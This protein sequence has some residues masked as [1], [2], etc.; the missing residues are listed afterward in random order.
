MIDEIEH[1]VVDD[2]DDGEEISMWQLGCERWRWWHI[3]SVEKNA[4]EKTGLAGLGCENNKIINSYGP[5]SA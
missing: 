2:D 3:T 5:A 4:S 1:G